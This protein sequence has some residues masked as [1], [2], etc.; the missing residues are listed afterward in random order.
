[1]RK[2]KTYIISEHVES[3]YKVLQENTTA[4]TVII[5]A[6]LQTADVFNRNGRK[7]PKAVLQKA[8][9]ADHIQ[10]LIKNG[11][12]V[13]EAG[14]PMGA[15]TSRQ[16]TI[17]PA[18]MSHRIISTRWEGNKLIGTIESLNTERGIEFKN[19]ILQGMR[20]AFSLRALGAA[21]QT[22]AGA[23][24]KDPMRM[25]CYDWVILPSH[26]EAYQLKIVNSLNESVTF[27]LEYIDSL[28]ATSGGVFKE[29]AL[30]VNKANKLSEN[31]EVMTFLEQVAAQV[32]QLRTNKSGDIIT[33]SADGSVKVFKTEAVLS[34]KANKV[35][36]NI[37]KSR[38]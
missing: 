33:E 32:D 34:R 2:L 8:L 30:P 38:F 22:P 20:V 11:S 4:G 7:Y 1:M 14:H 6:V 25:V 37:F 31:A 15:D 13:G 16:V 24:V 23:V 10:E 12:W 18:R 17:D 3:P 35:M 29:F 19:L 5:E 21:D 36:S 28:V 9:A 26:K 27:S